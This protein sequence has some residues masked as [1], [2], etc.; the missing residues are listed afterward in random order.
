[1]SCNRLDNLCWLPNVC[2]LVVVLGIVAEGISHATVDRSEIFSASLSGVTL[3]SRTPNSY[4]EL[5]ARLPKHDLRYTR[6]GNRF[7]TRGF[8]IHNNPLSCRINEVDY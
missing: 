2:T 8:R 7:A 3:F 5:L 1:M 4:D 6:R